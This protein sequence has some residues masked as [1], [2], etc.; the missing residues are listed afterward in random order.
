MKYY[1]KTRTIEEKVTDRQRIE[2][3]NLQ[4]ELLQK[5]LNQLQEMK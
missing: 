2:A 1:N 5:I 4:N 3:L